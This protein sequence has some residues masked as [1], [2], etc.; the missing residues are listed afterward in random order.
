MY[1]KFSSNSTTETAKLTLQHGSE[2]A[3][4]KPESLSVHVGKFDKSDKDHPSKDSHTHSNRVSTLKL[5]NKKLGHLLRVHPLLQ[6]F[7][8]GAGSETFRYLEII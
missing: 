5:L 8:D 1:Y 2:T 3:F 7:V 6:H 4:L